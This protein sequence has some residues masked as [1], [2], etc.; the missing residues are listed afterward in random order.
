MYQKMGSHQKM[1]S[2][3]RAYGHPGD[4]T[5][6]NLIKCTKDHGLTNEETSMIMS[7]PRCAECDQVQMTKHNGAKELKHDHV[8]I[9]NKMT[10]ASDLSG[11]KS[12]S[13]RG[14]KHYAVIIA[15]KHDG[16][17]MRTRFLMCDLLKHKSD[18]SFVLE[19]RL[20]E[21][22]NVTPGHWNCSSN[23]DE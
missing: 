13:I 7:L 12:M 22:K 21:I 9:P 11:K 18:L 3:H 8:H 15:C 6:L 14:Y 1:M 10:I 16:T 2:K 5:L 19:K 20:K 17:R 4:K 23:A